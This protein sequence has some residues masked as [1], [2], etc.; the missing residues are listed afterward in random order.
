MEE[1]RAPMPPDDKKSH[2][3]ACPFCLLTKTV[4]K[5]RKRHSAFFNHLMNAQIELLQAFKS[6]IDEQISS[7]EKKKEGMTDAKKATK[8]KVD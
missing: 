6:V 1:N 4:A 8:I 7:L 2:E 3:I 5:T